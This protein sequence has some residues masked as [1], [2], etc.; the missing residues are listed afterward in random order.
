MT[1]EIEARKHFFGVSQEDL[2]TA[3]SG[4][5]AVKEQLP[6]ILK[7]F[8]AHVRTVPHLAALIGNQEERLIAAQS[9]HWDGL[10][11]S[12][13]GQEYLESAKRIG[14]AHVRIDLDPTWYIGGYSFVQTRLA[15]YFLK[16]YRFSPAKAENVL[17]SMNK[18]IMIDMDLAISTYH[19][20]MIL[21]AENREAG[22]KAAIETFD[23]VMKSA[24]ETVGEASNAL[25]TTSGNLGNAAA[26]ISGRMQNMDTQCQDTA[27]SVSSSAAATEEMTSSIEEIGRQ[28]SES[29]VIARQAVDGAAKTNQSVQQ[30]AAAAEMVGSVISLISDIAAQ[31]N[32]LALNAT[33]EAARAGEMGKGFAVVAA[34]VKELASQTTRATEEITDQIASIQQATNQA[35][36]DISFITQT[37]GKVSE[38]ATSIASAVEEQTAATTEISHNVQ[39]AANNTEG[40]VSE[41]VLVRESVSETERSA[42]QIASMSGNL[43][44][45]AHRLDREAREFFSKVLSV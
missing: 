5:Q 3:K 32:L 29:S 6:G 45:Q 1:S 40:F 28:A 25:E 37:I 30:L 43:K 41:I 10:F 20:K 36:A 26:A 31:T 44:E 22:I 13:L 16:K 8:Y 38:I 11:T 18:L 42:G 15:S 2:A 7:D 23:G 34:E 4:W 33:I 21:D 27:A 19:D 12:G 24:L 14:L 39:T 9:R 35:A 17:R